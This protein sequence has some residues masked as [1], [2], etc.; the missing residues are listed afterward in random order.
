MP[1]ELLNA[2]YHIVAAAIIGA[3]LFWSLVLAFPLKLVAEAVFRF[4]VRLGSAFV[5]MLVSWIAISS[6]IL[7][8]IRSGWIKAEATTQISLQLI[9]LV[10]SLL[11]LTFCLTGIVRAPDGRTPDFAQS[12]VVAAIMQV[13]TLLIALALTFSGIK[14]ASGG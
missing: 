1:A 12:G 5:T 7:L 6:I 13:I 4:P 3:S 8:P 9:A 10:S 14:V 11:V 2:P